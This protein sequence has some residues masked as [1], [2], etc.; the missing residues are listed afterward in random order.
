MDVYIGYSGA[1]WQAV[2]AA[3]SYYENQVSVTTDPAS[4]VSISEA[5]LETLLNG[6]DA[7]NAL[8]MSAAWSTEAVFMQQIEG[9]PL[10][11]DPYSISVFQN[12]TSAYLA[13]ASGLGALVPPAA[14]FAPAATA[15]AAGSPIISDIGLLNFYESFLYETAPSG[16]TAANLAQTAMSIG[17]A[18]TNVANAI[19]FLQGSALTQL[20]DVAQREALAATAAAYIDSS[21]TSGGFTSNSGV[22]V[23]GIW[24]QMATLPAMAMSASILTSSPQSFA[25]QQSACIR[26]AMLS[27]AAQIERF[28]LILR[29]PQIN[30]VSLATLLVG[31]TL[32]DVAAR[33]LG[34]FELWPQIASLN[35]LSPPYTG[36]VSI[37][38]SGIAGYGSQ[39]ILPS[40]NT[41]NSSTGNAPSYLANFLGTDMYVGPINGAMPVWSGD[42]Q[43]ISGYNN[44]AWALG[45]RL[46]TTLSTLIYHLNYGSRIPPE[47]GNIQTN[48]TA[49][50]IAAFGKSAILSDPRVQNVLSASASLQQNGKVSFNGKVQP[51]GFG[52]NPVALNETISP[53]P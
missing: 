17:T 48:Q 18:F 7:V 21:F 16:T 51:A 46:Q 12:R 40:P 4:L 43:T 27:I 37:P 53:L 36:P 44:L 10:T 14:S 38:A 23:S 30:Q 3:L 39:L 15:F 49:S 25:N 34:N 32:M 1:V 41:S 29:K 19:Q 26:Y 5:M 31:E 35:G 11:L 24:N 33:T 47:V 50:R 45:R 22:T 20:Y 52:T 2:F 28:L 9:L 6:A 13:A 42:F 8:D